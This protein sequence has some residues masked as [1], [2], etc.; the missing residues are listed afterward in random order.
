MLIKKIHTIDRDGYYQGDEVL[1][2]P[3]NLIEA[4]A[5]GYPIVIRQ[6]P[7]DPDFVPEPDGLK[8]S[9]DQYFALNSFPNPTPEILQEKARIS[10][11]I[12]RL[13]REWAEQKR[14]SGFR[15]VEEFNVIPLNDRQIEAEIPSGFYKPKWDG[16]KWLEGMPIAEIDAINQQPIA[17]DNFVTQFIQS[18]LDESIAAS[19]NQVWITRLQIALDKRP[20]V[21]TEWVCWCWN[22]S[23]EGMPTPFTKA[24]VKVARS[25]VAENRIPFKVNA[26]GT[27]E[28]IAN[29]AESTPD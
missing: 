24:Q 7:I 27:I 17:W 21:E 22:K 1:E 6:E 29:E 4:K 11:E 14:L 20:N 13:E 25:I 15:E 2:I 23:V 3:E 16:F 8:L 19:S 12:D 18:D 9:R 28:A 26:N 10:L 5:L